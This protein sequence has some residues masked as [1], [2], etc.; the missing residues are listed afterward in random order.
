MINSGLISKVC[1][2]LNVNINV[3]CKK[4]K[5]NPIKK[6]AE[7]LNSHFSKEDTDGTKARENMLNIA[8]YSRNTN[9]N[10]SE[11][12]PYSGQNGHHQKVYK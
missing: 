7:D 4:K 8:N 2:Q 9:K 3:Q 10:Y 11:L 12:S 5:I 1:K 6:W